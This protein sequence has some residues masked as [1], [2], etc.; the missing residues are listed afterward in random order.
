RYDGLTGLPNRMSLREEMDKTLADLRANGSAAV[1]FVDLDQFKQVNDTLG[2]ARGDVLLQLVADR[3]RLAGAQSDVVA[4]FGGDEFVILHN[5][6][7]ETK[8]VE[9]LARRIITKLSETYA[10]DGHQVAIGATVGIALAPNDGTAT[11]HLLK[12]AD[13]ALYWAKNDQRGT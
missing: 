12:N 13:M 6:M 3:L 4:R 2:H 5:R 1:L 10:V 11:D 8:E 9:A 7:S